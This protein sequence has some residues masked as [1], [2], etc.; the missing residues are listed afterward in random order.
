[1]LHSNKNNNAP[2]VRS[3][4]T[5]IELLVVIA[6]IAIL[7]AILFP[8][9]ARARENARR[10]SCSSN[11]KQIG[12]GIVQYNQDYDEKFPLA[13]YSN[14]QTT[15]PVAVQPYIKSVQVFQCPSD[16]DAGQPSPSVPAG[17][18]GVG[19]SGQ[20][21]SYAGNSLRQNHLDGAGNNVYGFSGIFAEIGLTGPNTR[22]LAELES[23]STIVMVTD[24]FS[25]DT[26]TLSTTDAPYGNSSGFNRFSVIGLAGNGSDIPSGNRSTTG[27][28]PNTRMGLVSGRHLDT[29]NF[30]FADGHVKALKPELTNPDGN[31]YAWNGTRNYNNPKYL[32]SV[33]SG[34]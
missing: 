34:Q 8:V 25:S 12:L 30:L 15:W 19:W 20:K 23:P 9:F 26:S 33:Y 13:L 32:W 6:I 14:F 5:L 28:G 29:A 3:A 11:L 10:S 27:Y 17:G 21:I 1:M 31:Y 24:K 22:A 2:K 16:P 4:F 7:A 18:G